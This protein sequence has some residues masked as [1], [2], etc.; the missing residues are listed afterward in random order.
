MSYTSDVSICIQI[1]CRET[2]LYELVK[3]SINDNRIIL[4]STNLPLG[5]IIIK[6]DEEEHMIFERKSINDLACSIRDGRYNEQSYRFQSVNLHNHNII[7]LIEGNIMNYSNKYN[8]M[9]RNAL[10]SAMYSLWY[11]RGFSVI[12]TMNI[13]ETTELLLRFADKHLRE[14]NKSGF[15]TLHKK[16]I[17]NNE[18]MATTEI[19]HT[20][21]TVHANHYS[22]V[23]KRVRKHN[24]TPDNISEIILSQIPGI[25]ST[26]AKVVMEKYNSIYHL[27]DSLKKNPSCID[28]LMYTTKSGQIRKVSSKSIGFIKKYLLSERMKE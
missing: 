26:T 14:K 4:E 20:K 25:S 22:E 8:K 15:Y 11:T 10:F 13:E 3:N 17:S 18:Y 21:D 2:K 7:Y 24:I 28:N 27:I 19:R 16:D 1:D 6:V 12:R 23:V 9:S 5:D